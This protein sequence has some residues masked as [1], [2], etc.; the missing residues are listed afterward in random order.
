MVIAD[1]NFRG[2]VHFLVCTNWVGDGEVLS[3]SGRRKY[4][5]KTKFSSADCHA[6]PYSEN[7]IY[8]QLTVHRIIWQ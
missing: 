7:K 6:L 4:R 8:V 5:R 2:R 3:V 1:H